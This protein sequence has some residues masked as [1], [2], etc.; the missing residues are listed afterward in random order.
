MRASF[1]NAGNTG[2]NLLADIADVHIL[3]AAIPQTL[4]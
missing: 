1:N 3:P 4:L 2:K